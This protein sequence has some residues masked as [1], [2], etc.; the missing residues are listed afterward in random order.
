MTSQEP[1][2]KNG[3]GVRPDSELALDPRQKRFMSLYLNTDSVTFGNC[4]R[5][6]IK[7]GFSDLTAR[8]L[9]HNKPKWYSEI[10]GQ[11]QGVQ[12]E[13]LLLKLT[14]IINDT[15]VSTQNKLKAIDMLMKH[16]GM[17]PA[18]SH[19][20]LNLNRINIQSVLD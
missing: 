14:D 4:Y 12:P 18:V 6:A 1:K 9:T 7:A 5:S 15:G 8:N 19:N 16:N 11:Q 13:H 3:V 10:L 2:T 20:T 17:Y